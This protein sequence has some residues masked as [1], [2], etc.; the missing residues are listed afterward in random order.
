MTSIANENQTVP[1][2][3][4]NL[5]LIGGFDKDLACYKV[6]IKSKGGSNIFSLTSKRNNYPFALQLEA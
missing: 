6:K 2:L 5:Y 1:W 3:N 4:L